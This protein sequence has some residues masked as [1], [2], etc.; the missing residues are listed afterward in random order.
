MNSLDAIIALCALLAGFGLIIGAIGAQK[1][2]AE[3]A[4]WS[5]KAKT[6]AL[7]CSAAVDFVFSNGA[8]GYEKQFD[9][10]AEGTAVK[11][12]E[13]GKEKSV[14]IITSAKKSNSLEVKML[15]HYLK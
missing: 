14:P 5:V 9:C 10:S 12:A 7:G 4:G 11:S 15:E 8:E 13:N 1:E 6:N 2:L 3:E